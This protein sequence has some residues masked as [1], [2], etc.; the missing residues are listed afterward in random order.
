MVKSA[1][2]PLYTSAAARCDLQQVVAWV[3][4]MFNH[5]AQAPHMSY[6][7]LLFWLLPE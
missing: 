4:D 3:I 1:P 2:I 6:N 5:L 7:L